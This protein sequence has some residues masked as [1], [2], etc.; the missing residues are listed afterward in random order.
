MSLV[1]Y[2]AVVTTPRNDQENRRSVSDDRPCGAFSRPA[3][4][5]KT[6]DLVGNLVEFPGFGGGIIGP[7]CDR[8]T[9]L[10]PTGF[11]GLCKFRKLH[12]VARSG[13]RHDDAGCTVAIRPECTVV[14]QHAS[15][16]RLQVLGWSVWRAATSPP[17]P[18][19][20]A[21]RL[22]R[23]EEHTSELQ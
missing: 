22:Q 15:L 9:A 13:T 6:A 4:P 18:R 16:A 17:R 2:D 11:L 10:A 19:R 12:F 5:K 14:E 20:I 1:S 21:K 23:S 3:A 8:K 7:R